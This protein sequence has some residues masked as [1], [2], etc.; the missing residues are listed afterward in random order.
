MHGVLEIDE[1][2]VELAEARLDFLEVVR[3]TLDLGGHGVEARAG[4]GLNILDGLLERAHGAFD[5][6][7]AGVGLVNDGAHAGV[8]LGHLGGEILL[9][10]EQGGDVAL[11]LD[12]FA[13][14]GLGGAG[15]EQASGKSAS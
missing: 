12:E 13:G 5:L 10:L 6:A 1:L 9:A 4:I 2:L 3:E 15:A 11:K 14:D 7:E 8:I